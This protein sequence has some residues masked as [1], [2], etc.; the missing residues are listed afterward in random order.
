MQTM[1]FFMSYY[2]LL[3][4]MFPGVADTS[5]LMYY[6]TNLRLA[7]ARGLKVHSNDGSVTVN[8]VRLLARYKYK[9]R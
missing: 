1:T 6:D 7:L 2:Y 9:E 3:I 4:K 5:G 8:T